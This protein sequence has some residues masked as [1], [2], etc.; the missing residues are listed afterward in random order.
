[1]SSVRWPVVQRGWR[2][3]LSCR[4]SGISDHAIRPARFAPGCRPRGCSHD[5]RAMPRGPP[6]RRLAAP[7]SVAACALPVG[8][9]PG[10]TQL[11]WAVR[12]ESWAALVT[13]LTE[14]GT[15]PLAI[16]DLGAGFPW[17]SHRLASLGHAVLAVDLSPDIDFGLRP[18]RLFPTARQWDDPAGAP[19]RPGHFLA[20]WGTWNRRR[21]RPRRRMS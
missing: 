9:P 13:L 8:D 20:S 1:M 16:A 14:L 3:E 11:Y 12:H 6:G 21:W 18:A 10:F 15:A 2:A 19:W 5:H 4:R 7:S 17:L